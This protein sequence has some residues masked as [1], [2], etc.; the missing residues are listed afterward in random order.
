M[1]YI[2]SSTMKA[3]NDLL[4][5]LGIKRGAGS[6]YF[7]LEERLQT[8]LLDLAAEEKRPAGELETELI[9]AG[10]AQRQ[11]KNEWVKCW[12]S[13]S[14]REQQVAALTCLGY[15][16]LQIAVRLMIAEETVKTHMRNLLVKFNLH[17]KANLRQ[18]LSEWDFS[19]W[20]K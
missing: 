14:A 8:K 4:V 20:E 5:R 10:L 15:T 1:F 17:G 19:E 7:E 3:L 11:S 6:R 16:N 9:E 2:I 13:L 12:Q 18:A